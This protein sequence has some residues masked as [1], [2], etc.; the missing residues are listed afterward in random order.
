MKKQHLLE[1]EFNFQ[2]GILKLF[3]YI[4]IRSAVVALLSMKMR[5]VQP[6]LNTKNSS[7]SY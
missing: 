5:V 4:W 1:C 7:K 6:I 2:F 3:K